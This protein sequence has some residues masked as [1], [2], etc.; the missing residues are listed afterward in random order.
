MKK[1]LTIILMA[2]SVMALAMLSACGVFGNSSDEISFYIDEE[3]GELIYVHDGGYESLGKVTGKD[4][5]DVTVMDLYELYVAETGNSDL[6]VEDFIQGFLDFDIVTDNSRSVNSCLRSAVKVFAEFPM[7]SSGMG[8]IG[9]DRVSYVELVEGSGIIYDTTTSSDYIYIVTNY[10]V[11]YESESTSSDKISNNIHVYLYGSEGE[12]EVKEY[13]NSRMNLYVTEYEYDSYA[14][15]CEYVGGSLNSDIAVLKAS[16]DDVYA[17][18]DGVVAVERAD[19]DEYGNSYSVGETCFT[20]GNSEGM[21]LSVTQGI[22]SVDSEYISLTIGTTTQSYRSIRIDTAMYSGNSGGGLFNKYGKLIGVVN[23][24]S[25]S[26]ESINFAI[27]LSI[28]AGTADN[29]IYYDMLGDGEKCAKTLKDYWTVSSENSRYVYD[30]TMGYGRIEEDAVV[31]SV[32]PGGIQD[33]L[34]IKEGDIIT[35]ITVDGGKN[36]I[37]RVYQI[38]DMNLVLRPGDVISYTYIRGGMTY[39]T[40]SFALDSTY[41]SKRA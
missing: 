19:V 29:I 15:E 17:I 38:S 14:I 9:Q 26:D 33:S 10:H 20:I 31:Q 41:F 21:G 6:T 2:L 16:K 35:G 32:T 11:V 36:I 4:A 25:T 27:P 28:A 7:S 12:P 13:T 1:F 39:E 40:D 34:G 3:T 22:V 18:N 23:A 37:T 30:S 24:G 8:I 5:D